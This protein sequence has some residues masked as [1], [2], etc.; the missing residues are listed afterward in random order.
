MLGELM[1]ELREAETLPDDIFEKKYPW[2]YYDME[3]VATEK[4]FA[5]ILDKLED[6]MLDLKAEAEYRDV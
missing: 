1:H 5:Y 3:R 2:S 4:A 6:V